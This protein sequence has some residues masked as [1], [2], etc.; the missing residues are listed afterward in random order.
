MLPAPQNLLLA[1]QV[2]KQNLHGILIGKGNSDATVLLRTLLKLT[3]R[4]ARRVPCVLC[5]YLPEDSRSGPVI[6]ILVRIAKWQEETGY[7]QADASKSTHI[8]DVCIG[9]TGKYSNTLIG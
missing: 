6:L 1:P 7:T 3:E 4:T 5:S 8:V 9:C 2:V